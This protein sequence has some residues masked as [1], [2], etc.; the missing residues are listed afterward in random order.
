MPTT[1]DES[2]VF[3]GRLTA[4][5]GSSPIVM[6][7]GSTSNYAMLGLKGDQAPE[8]WQV[9][10]TLG[11]TSEFRV[12]YPQNSP[13]LTVYQNGNV[14]VAGSITQGCSRT[15]KDN[16]APLSASEAVEALT[17]LNPV[18]FHYKSDTSQEQHI[19]FI[20]EDVPDLVATSD[21]K[22]LSAMDIVAVL[23][24]VVK[25]QQK[26][27]SELTEKVERLEALA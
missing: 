6:L 10:A 5:G 19:G 20:A 17:N 9:Q 24:Q 18:K 21:R 22:G 14:S 27:I 15:I 13:K 7:H 2:V 25:Q 4:I 23:T 12:A 1:F 26:V 8:Y 16:I 3:K 11:S